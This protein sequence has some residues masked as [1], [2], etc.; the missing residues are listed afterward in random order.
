M[1]HID[2]I[3]LHLLLTLLFLFHIFLYLFPQ[4]TYYGEVHF[5]NWEAGRYEKGYK[6]VEAQGRAS[7][8][9]EQDLPR[10]YGIS[11]ERNEGLHEGN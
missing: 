1:P 11:N 7:E 4:Q 5:G 8:A 10:V 6:D 9:S 3:L 2:H